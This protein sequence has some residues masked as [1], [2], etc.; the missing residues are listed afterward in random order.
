MLLAFINFNVNRE[1]Q[2]NP[3]GELVGGETPWRGDDP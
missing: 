2:F 3:G 1:N